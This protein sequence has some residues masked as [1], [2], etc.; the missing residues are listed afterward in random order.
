MTA[1]IRSSTSGR[2]TS[3]T[4][5]SIRATPNHVYAV[6]EML[7]ESKDGGRKFK[8]IAKDV[9]VDYHAI[10]IAPNNPKRI[11]VGEDGGYALTTDCEH[12]SFSR[13]LA[14]GQIYHVGLSNENP[15]QVCAAFQDRPTDR[16]TSTNRSIRTTTSGRTE[17]SISRHTIAAINSGPISTAT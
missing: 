6:S 3:R 2:S 8:E 10:W 12:W 5:P 16:T 9:H 1:T 4:S 7:S 14:I 15:Y 13:N 11:I 17:T